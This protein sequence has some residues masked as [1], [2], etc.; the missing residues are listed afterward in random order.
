MSDPAD[1]LRRS[2]LNPKRSAET[3]AEYA[4]SLIRLHRQLY[5]AHPVDRV[6]KWARVGALLPILRR[7]KHTTKKKLVAQILVALRNWPDKRMAWMPAWHELC[8][9]VE[10]KAN[11]QRTPREER[12][13]VTVDQVSS[14]LQRLE[15]QLGAIRSVATTLA[16]RRSVMAHLVLSILTLM[17]AL[18]TQNLSD[19]KLVRTEPDPTESNVLVCDKKGTFTLVLHRFKT[20]N[21]YGPQRIKFPPA[22]CHVMA[23][24]LQLFPRKFMCAKLRNPCEGMSPNLMSQFC[25]TLF[26]EEGKRVG[27]TLLRKLTVTTVYANKPSLAS[28]CKLAQQ[29][30]H[31]ADVARSHYF[32]KGS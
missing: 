26:A 23:R 7:Y 19:I 22:L 32:K 16:E 11:G 25:G 6:D 14:K 8:K 15:S 5:S 30:L 20:S 1:R 21:T 18:R 4:D 13:W 31:S 17:P 2:L 3:S 24:S 9:K 29:M 27:P 10:R 28:Q 12:N